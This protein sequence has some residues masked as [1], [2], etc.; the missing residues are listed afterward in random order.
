[1]QIWCLNRYL[2]RYKGNRNRVTISAGGERQSKFSSPPRTAPPSRKALSK[3][4]CA[5]Q[6]GGK[7]QK[8]LARVLLPLRAALIRFYLLI[9]Y[10]QL[11]RSESS[12]NFNL[13]PS[14]NSCGAFLQELSPLIC[15]GNVDILCN[16][17][18]EIITVLSNTV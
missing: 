14:D 2:V 11:L 5:L 6:K 10:R 12:K 8:L 3:R 16:N 1:M 7:L 13:Q 17:Q 9:N 18:L 15:K 4:Y